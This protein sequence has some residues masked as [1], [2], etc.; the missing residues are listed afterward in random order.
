M[1]LQ[2]F[3][4]FY[5]FQS[6]DFEMLYSLFFCERKEATQTGLLPAYQFMEFIFAEV[7]ES[8]PLLNFFARYHHTLENLEE[9]WGG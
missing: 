4:D 3:I 6:C 2:T 7:K 1:K 8:F 5:V 9:G